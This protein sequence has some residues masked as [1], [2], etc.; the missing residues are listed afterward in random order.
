MDQSESP[1]GDK[2]ELWVTIA[3]IKS[4]DRLIYLIY[5]AL[6]E[7]AFLH[8]KIGISSKYD[9]THFLT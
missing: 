4:S 6:K 7:S 9:A 2:R 5:N 8:C 1:V 3:G